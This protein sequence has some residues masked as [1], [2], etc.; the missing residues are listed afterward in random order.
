MDLDAIAGLGR[1]T[2]A[3][4]EDGDVDTRGRLGGLGT[5]KRGVGQNGSEGN[6]GCCSELVHE[7]VFSCVVGWVKRGTGI[8]VSGW[9]P[10]LSSALSS[11][12][13]FCRQVQSIELDVAG[14]DDIGPFGDLGRHARL[15]GFRAAANQDDAQ[16]QQ[17]F[18]HVG[19]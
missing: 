10:L 13:K 16:P 19:L 7:M 9:V 4:D 3:L 6:S 11:V 8:E 5:G 17:L 12:G 18:L 15:C 1:G 14:L 2:G